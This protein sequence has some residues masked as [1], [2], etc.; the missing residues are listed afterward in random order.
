VFETPVLKD[1]HNDTQE[2]LAVQSNIVDD[3]RNKYLTFHN[4]QELY[5][6]SNRL[7]S[8]SKMIENFVAIPTTLNIQN[9]MQNQYNSGWSVA[10][11][12]NMYCFAQ[13]YN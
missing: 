6:L 7:R 9:E 2:A 11:L 4:K 8:V 13:L 5:S 10:A 12:N 1:L 3:R